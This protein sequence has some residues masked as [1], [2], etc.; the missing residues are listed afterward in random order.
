MKTKEFTD[1]DEAMDFL[2]LKESQ[3]YSAV[4]SYDFLSYTVYYKDYSCK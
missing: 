2:E 4:L 1:Y 3:G